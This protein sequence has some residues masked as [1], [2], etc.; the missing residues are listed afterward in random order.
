VYKIREGVRCHSLRCAEPAGGFRAARLEREVT[1]RSKTHRMSSPG[2]DS[3]FN[4]TVSRA[5]W[6]SVA[7]VAL[8]LAAGALPCGQSQENP[9]Q[10][11][12]QQNPATS[13]TADSTPAPAQTPADLLAQR[14]AK[15]SADLL[16]LAAELKTEVSKSTKDTLSLAV[17]R[18]ADEIE[19]VARGMKDRYR[20]NGVAN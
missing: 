9:A 7:A 16:K 8:L 5:R 3:D 19:R 17:I 13:K 20:A 18:K 12:P 2:F 10:S 14:T 1:V 11:Q 4:A 6:K 15:E